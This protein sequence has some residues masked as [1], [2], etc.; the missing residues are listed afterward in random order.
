MFAIRVALILGAVSFGTSAIAGSGHTFGFSGPEIFPV[1]FGIGFLRHADFDGDGLED[2]V[3]VN[4]RRSKITFLYNQTGRSP[5]ERESS[6]ASSRASEPNELPPDARFRIESIAS[7]KQ[8]SSLVVDDFNGSG[9]PDLAYFGDPKELVIQYNLGPD[10]WSSPR[11]FDLS[12]GLTDMNALATGDLDGDGLSDLVLLAERHLYVL[13]QQPDGT[14]GE[15]EKLPYSGVVKSVQILDVDGDNRNDLLLV[16]WDHL[17]PFRFRRQNVHGNLGP[18]VHLGMAP[19]RSYWADN[20]DG[21]GPT[22]IV[23]IAA[24]SGRAAVS[25]LRR[26]AAENISEGVADGQFAVVPLPRTDKTRRGTAWGDVDGDGLLD[27]LVADPEAGQL[28]VHR[29][30]EERRLSSAQ[31]F[32]SLSGISDIAVADWDQDGHADVF[33]LS[34]DEKQIGWASADSGGRLSFP[35]SLPIQGRPLAM[36]VGELKTGTFV[37]AAISEREERREGKDDRTETVTIREVV[38]VG[39][40]L[41]IVSQP[42]AESYKATPGSIAF[43]DVD[44]DGLMD[45]V[46]LTPYERIKILRQLEVPKEGKVFDEI[47][48]NPPG[49]NTDRPWMARA[50]VNGDGRPELLLAQK[51]FVRA[52]VLQKDAALEGGWSLDVRDQINGSSSSSRIVGASALPPVAGRAPTVFLLDADRKALTVSVR[53]TNG[54]WATRRNVALPLTD[55]QS[56]EHLRF[57]T[58]GADGGSGAVM[59]QGVNVLAW[60][61]LDGEV[62]ELVKLDGY[63]TPIKD[64]YLNDLTSGDLNGDGRRDLVFLETRK[65]HIDVVL[66]EPPHKLV[67]ANRWQVFEERTFRQR[68][69]AEIPEPREA[70]VIDL[71]GD[72]RSDLAILVHD[73]ILLYPQE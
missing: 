53:D 57:D 70:L 34:G 61:E 6:T 45:L 56:I 40:D 71:T 54:V 38:I 12:D 55:F 20:L 62:W 9:R 11:R 39:S 4:N 16:N 59:L 73:R 2:I 31:A 42:L 63:E 5:S 33:L 72:G 30:D 10:G 17:Y 13:R 19:I 7:E 58:S 47:D 49:G 43:H 21:K 24:K 22:E 44:Q 27:L 15:P 26:V 48:V 32:P 1:E 25:N 8:I 28:L 18:E 52:V 29:Q 36:A 67:P 46:L 35:K 51:N 68:R 37:L 65:A 3:L 50:D 60:K 14:M 23:T 69:G 66:F 41:K 64:G